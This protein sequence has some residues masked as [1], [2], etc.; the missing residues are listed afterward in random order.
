MSA[1]S[2]QSF[3]WAEQVT[4][5]NVDAP[6]A[7]LLTNYDGYFTGGSGI[8]VTSQGRESRSSVKVGP[9]GYVTRTSA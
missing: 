3:V 9:I 1:L 2:C 4:S 5:K 8:K 7:V 6:P